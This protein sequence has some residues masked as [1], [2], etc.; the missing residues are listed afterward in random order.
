M[1]GSGFIFR[2]SITRSIIIDTVSHHQ[3]RDVKVL[4]FTMP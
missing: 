4:F 3:T 2:L 1:K